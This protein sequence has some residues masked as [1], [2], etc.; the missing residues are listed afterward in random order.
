M[1]NE[2]YFVDRMRHVTLNGRNCKLV[3]VYKKGIRANYFEGQFSV[4]ERTANKRVLEVLE[5]R[6]DLK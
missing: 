1:E 2:K 5:L 3:T 6:G 4:P